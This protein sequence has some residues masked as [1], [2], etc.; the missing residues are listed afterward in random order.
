MN[1]KEIKELETSEIESINKNQSE[2]EIQARSQ[3][4]RME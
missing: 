3:D 4:P 2:E 1:V